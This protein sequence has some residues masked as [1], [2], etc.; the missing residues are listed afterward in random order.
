MVMVGETGFIVKRDPDRVRG[1]DVAFIRQERI[2]ATG[3]PESFWAIAP[4]LAVEV[5]SPSDTV[6]DPVLP[7]V[8]CVVRELFE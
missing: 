1:A 8:R 5:L 3:V 7:G 6:R 2:P 4:D